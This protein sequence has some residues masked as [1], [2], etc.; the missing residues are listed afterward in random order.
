MFNGTNCDRKS[1]LSEI[2]TEP[3]NPRGASSTV[4]MQTICGTRGFNGSVNVSGNCDFRS[5]FDPLYIIFWPFLQ[6]TF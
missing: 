1:Q 3:L 6:N 5:Q 4:Q 2:L